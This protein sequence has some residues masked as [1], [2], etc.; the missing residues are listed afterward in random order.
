M[1]IY[2]IGAVAAI[3]AMYPCVRSLIG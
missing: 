2:I 3:G 1:E